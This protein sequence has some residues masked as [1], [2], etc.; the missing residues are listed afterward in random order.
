MTLLVEP[1]TVAR[2]GA[3]ARAAPRQTPSGE[4]ARQRNHVR[5]R[6]AAIHA[7]RVQ[8]HQLAR[9]V[10]VQS[11]E[12]PLRRRAAGC[13]V[14]PVVE[15]EQHRR[16]LRRRAQQVA[17]TAEHVRAYRLLLEGAGPETVQALAG[18]DVE[19]VEPELDH[20]LLELSRA[21][22]GAQQARFEG[23]AEHASGTLPLGLRRGR[24]ARPGLALARLAG[25]LAEQLDRRH[26]Q[27][28]ERLQPATQI[29]GERY[30]ARVKLT[31]DPGVGAH[32]LQRRDVTRAR[33][34]G[35]TRE[36]VCRLRRRTAG[37]ARQRRPEQ[38]QHAHQADHHRSS[39]RSSVTHR[40][41]PSSETSHATGLTTP[42]RIG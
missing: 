30:V 24:V 20:H 22:D 1:E 15:I 36:Q 35:E 28:L 11:L 33:T 6:V 25:E 41:P 13:G 39:C 17:E 29:L 21:F 12:A 19:M 27:R 8:L 23:L 31:F 4:N 38:C 32:R 9:V 37:S 10:F 16:V 18:E 5:L 34:I 40:N 7:E 14:T 3:A 42:G 26:A 2:G